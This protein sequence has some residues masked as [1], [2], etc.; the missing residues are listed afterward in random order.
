V[1]S[2]GDEA[3]LLFDSI[4]GL[5]KPHCILHCKLRKRDGDADGGGFMSVSIRKSVGSNEFGFM[6]HSLLIS[7]PTLIAL[8]VLCTYSLERKTEVELYI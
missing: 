6:V 7:R 4:L 5:H 2:V 1:E 8:Y 3:E